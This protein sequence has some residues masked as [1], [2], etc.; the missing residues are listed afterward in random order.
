MLAGYKFDLLHL[1]DVL[2]LNGSEDDQTVLSALMLDKPDWIVLDYEQA[3]FGNSHNTNPENTMQGCNFEHGVQSDLQQLSHVETKMQPLI[4]QTSGPYHAVCLDFMI[5]ELG[6]AS[7]E[8]YLLT[9]EFFDMVADFNEEENTSNAESIPAPSAPAAD[10]DPMATFFGAGNEDPATTNRNYGIAPDNTDEPT[11]NNVG[12]IHNAP[13]LTSL[14]LRNPIMDMG[15]IDQATTSGITA[16]ATRPIIFR[17]TV[18]AFL[19]TEDSNVPEIQ[20]R[21]FALSIFNEHD[22]C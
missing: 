15:T 22:Q 9:S 3:M 1:L 4:L 18:G 20:V 12:S 7:Q 6:G 8:R 21:F 13:A 16:P 17:T 10:E 14:I 5:E 11:G 2:K 19:L